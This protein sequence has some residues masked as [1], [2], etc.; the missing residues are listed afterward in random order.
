[1][2]QRIQSVYLFL[3]ALLASLFLKGSI[4]TFNN[5]SGRIRMNLT[6]IS[7]ANVNN[8]LHPGNNLVPLAVIIA[9]II[10][11][12]ISAVFFFRKR[13]LQMKLTV[14]LIIL[15]LVF[16][17]ALVYYAISVMNGFQAEIT[18]NYKMFLPVIMIILS[19]LAYRGI[20]KDEDLVRSYDRLR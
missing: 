7:Q 15:E 20:R 16:A 8:T 9:L 1:M 4:L 12:A 2:I 3:T 18:L 13:K 6:G 14:L 5:I 10:I 19:V 11:V 17:G